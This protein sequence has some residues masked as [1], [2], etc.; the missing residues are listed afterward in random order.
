M[1]GDTTPPVPPADPTP[2][3]SNPAAVPGPP[4][5][6]EIPAAPQGPERVLRG[7]LLSL[8]VLPAGVLLF[9]LIWNI[10]FVSALVGFAVA[11]G[12]FFLYRFGSGG[13]ISIR[14]AILI[15]V[16][17]LVTLLV[18]YPFATIISPFANHLAVTQ[19]YVYWGLIVD[20]TFWSYAIAERSTSLPSNFA[21]YFIL[22]LVFGGLGCFSLLRN[23]FKQAAEP[24]AP[25]GPTPPAAA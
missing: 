22:T 12:A 23:A 5:P 7:F 24:Q 15:T 6:A 13:R 1:S 11:F 3:G 25:A 8:L 21:L 17:T 20:P 18:A 14:G 10:G 9:T 2:G 4:T 16:V 19:G